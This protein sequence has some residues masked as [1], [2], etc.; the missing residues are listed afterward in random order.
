MSEQ[1]VT[2]YMEAASFI[3]AVAKHPCNKKLYNPQILNAICA[4]L[5]FSKKSQDTSGGSL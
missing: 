2:K 3:K 5:N 1:Y 4:N